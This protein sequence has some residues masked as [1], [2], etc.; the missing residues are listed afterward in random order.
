[1]RPEGVCDRGARASSALQRRAVE[2]KLAA[3]REK[4]AT[5]SETELGRINQLLTDVSPP[6]APLLRSDPP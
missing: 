5:G 1:M 6:E 2:P 4:L 3:R